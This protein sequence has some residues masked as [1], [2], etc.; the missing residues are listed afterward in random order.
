MGNC[1]KTNEIRE[2]LM[3]FQNEYERKDI[4]H[5]NEFVRGF[6]IDEED[7]SLVG[8]GIWDWH[9]GINSISDAVKNYWLNDSEYLKNIEFDIDNSIIT[10]EGSTAVAAV[11]GKSTNR[12]T[13]EEMFDDMMLKIKKELRGTDNEKI[14]LMNVSQKIARAFY[15]V[16]LGENFVWP[17]RAT[18]LLVNKD[19][20]WMFKHVNLSFGANN[21]WEFWFTDENIPGEYKTLPV[22]YEENNE[23]E[24]IRR[25]LYRIQEGYDK[26]D[27]SILDDFA[28]EIFTG[29]EN[30]FIFGTDAGENFYGPNAGHD[31]CEGDWIYWGDFDINADKA[32]I[33]VYD[34]MAFVYSKAFLRKQKDRQRT[35]N[36]LGDLFHNYLLP[37][38]ESS[39]EKL[40]R[41]LWKTTNRVH[42]SEY[43][44]NFIVP[45][46]FSG[47]LIKTD[48]TWRFQ[49][50]HFTDN[51]DEM[52]E[53]R[54]IEG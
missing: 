15:E 11:C 40:L 27:V 36:S 31:L 48:N 51:I 6:F 34:N 24:E 45:M 14:E 29:D 47:V 25:V 50:M 53:E 13:K 49:H 33:S 20:K 46:K 35:Y 28:K 7:T 2:T 30:S 32:Y 54:I 4:E 5:V 52:P 38:E 41:M 9:F 43:P 44:G 22:K 21:G 23:V 8:T 42:Y 26:R 18:F 39:E 10:V 16:N 3:R 19:S 17:F 1:S 12:I 37:S